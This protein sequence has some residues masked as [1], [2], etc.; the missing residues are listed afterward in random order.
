MSIVRNFARAVEKGLSTVGVQ[1]FLLRRR[2]G[3]DYAVIDKNYM[4]RYYNQGSFIKLYNRAMYQTNSQSRDSFEKQV[5]YFGLYQAAAH[6]LKAGIE[7]S[8]V[9]CG[10]WRGH[11][12]FIVAQLIKD[13]GTRQRLTIVDSFEG[14]LSEKTV[15]DKMLRATVDPK[16]VANEKAAFYSTEQQVKAALAEYEF[17]DY[18]KGWIP[19]PFENM[20][21]ERFAFVNLDLDLYAPVKE[22]PEFLYPRLNEGGILV[23]DDYGTTDWPGVKAAVDQFLTSNSASFSLETIGSII[24]IK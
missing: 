15:E 5:R 13:C 20:R 10:C 11:S 8:F 4:E 3:S 1:A 2:K 19:V 22:S 18:Y 14:G 7:G 21:E 23:V 9:E 6:V 17:V 16:E 12:A 24:I